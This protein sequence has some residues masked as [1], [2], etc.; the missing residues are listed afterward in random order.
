MYYV[1]NTGAII[2]PNYTILGV[3]CH[4]Y[5]VISPRDPVEIIKA[6]ILGTENA[7]TS[8]HCGPRVGIISSPKLYPCELLELN[9]LVL[10]GEW[11]NGLWRLFLGIT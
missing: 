6:P 9:C 3:P 11:G 10:S 1:P 4:S 2:L 8:L 5:S 7:M